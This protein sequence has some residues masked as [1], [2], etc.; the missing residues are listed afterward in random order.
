MA[1][2]AE[3]QGWQVRQDTVFAQVGAGGA[4]GVGAGGAGVAVV[5]PETGPVVDPVGFH[6]P[7]RRLTPFPRRY[8][9]ETL[10][11]TDP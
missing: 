3:V 5:A 7:G 1:G 4:T 2:E 11:H 8:P 6:V 9:S 10:A